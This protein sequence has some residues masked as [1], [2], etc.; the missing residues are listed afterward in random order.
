MLRDRFGRVPDEADSL[1][2]TFLAKAELEALGIRRVSFT[3]ETYLVEYA[4]RI[5][6]E[7]WLG[8]LGASLRTLRTG[9][10]HLPI[11]RLDSRI[12]TAEEAFD[13]L[14]GLLRGT[15]DATRMPASRAH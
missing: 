4:D 14:E 9:V 13:W 3:G 7:E 8:P 12:R 15:E 2:R 11:P 6:V 10:G 1:V 5:A